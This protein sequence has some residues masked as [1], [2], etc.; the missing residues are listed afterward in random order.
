MER[1]ARK[2]MAG[3]LAQVSDQPVMVVGVVPVEKGARVVLVVVVVAARPS[4]SMQSKVRYRHA[5][6]SAP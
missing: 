5:R 1:A 6:K 2:A 4:E 3:N